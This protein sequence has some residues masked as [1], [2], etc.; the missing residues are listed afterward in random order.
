V[1]ITFKIFYVLFSFSIFLCFFIFVNFVVVCA[2]K[3]LKGRKK[4]KISMAISRVACSVSI[5]REGKD[6]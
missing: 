6:N 3:F 5:K 1:N 2:F 4:E